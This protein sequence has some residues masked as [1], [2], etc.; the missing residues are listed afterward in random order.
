MK[1][2]GSSSERARRR[3]CVGASSGE[4]GADSMRGLPL[5]LMKDDVM[6]LSHELRFVDFWKPTNGRQLDIAVRRMSGWERRT[7]LNNFSS[8]SDL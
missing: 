8:E 1:T 3:T 6:D 4:D 7:D 2:F 5:P